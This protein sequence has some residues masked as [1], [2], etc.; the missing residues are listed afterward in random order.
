MLGDLTRAQQSDE[1]VEMVD[2][3]PSRPFL[4]QHLSVHAA[5]PS[6]Q[7]RRAHMIQSRRASRVGGRMPKLGSFHV[8]SVARIPEDEHV[9]SATT[10]AVKRAPRSPRC[11]WWTPSMSAVA[12][13]QVTVAALIVLLLLLFSSPAQDTLLEHARV[14]MRA[15]LSAA[16]ALA[17]S[18]WATA[19]AV[20]HSVASELLSSSEDLGPASAQLAVLWN[21]TVARVPLV[22]GQ[23]LLIAHHAIRF[24]PFQAANLPAAMLLF[25]R[26]ARSRL[27]CCASRWAD[28]WHS[29]AGGRHR[30]AGRSYRPASLASDAARGACAGERQSALGSA[31]HRKRPECVAD[32]W[33]HCWRASGGGAGAV[34]GHVSTAQLVGRCEWGS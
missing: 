15:S 28:P 23:A 9:G 21:A 18:E 14:S 32:Q 26:A 7:H 20:V 10:T 8:R 4:R 29:A 33:W 22:S 34:A 19:R 24:A 30:H 13:I 25:N 12:G 16:S 27:H 17:D 1:G 31:Q 3:A 6:L 11:A 5:S 2:R